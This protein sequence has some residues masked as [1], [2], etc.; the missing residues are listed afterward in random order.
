M[1]YGHGILGL[2]NGGL[3]IAIYMYI[4]RREDKVREAIAKVDERVEKVDK[5][6]DSIR[7]NYIKQFGAVREKINC[8]E[9]A[10]LEK[11]TELLVIVE[12]LKKA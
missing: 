11:I 5:E 6:N 7:V 4:Q 9:K 2:I 3:L 12:G 1:D 8:T 10:I